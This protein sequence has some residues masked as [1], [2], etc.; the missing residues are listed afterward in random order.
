[1]G[2]GRPHTRGRTRATPED[3]ATGPAPAGIGL[4]RRRLARDL[5]VFGH[6]PVSAQAG[7]TP[8]DARLCAAVGRDPRP[9]LLATAPVGRVA[10]L[11]P[12]GPARPARGPRLTKPMT[13]TMRHHPRASGARARFKPPD[14]DWSGCGEV[15]WWPRGPW[16]E[17][18][19][20]PGGLRLDE[21]REEGR[22]TTV[23]SG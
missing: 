23:K 3:G 19:L 17:T 7:G 6:L 20:G 15:G 9:V 21:W 1:M 10:G 16:R 8:G 22:L 18:L 14:W 4:L 2:R 11:G 13:I 5:R 12:R